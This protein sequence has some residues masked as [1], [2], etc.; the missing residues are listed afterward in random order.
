MRRACS[1]TARI[2][3][4]GPPLR[5][6][7]ALLAAGVGGAARSG[8]AAPLRPFDLQPLWPA[9][10]GTLGLSRQL[11]PKVGELRGGL[12][13]AG[14]DAGQLLVAIRDRAGEIGQAGVGGRHVVPRLLCFGGQAIALLRQVGDLRLP[15]LP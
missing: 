7:F 9:S 14:R 2:S 8:A 6:L 3:P 1:F 13:D 12:L 10:A 4:R 5:S 15:L 11:L